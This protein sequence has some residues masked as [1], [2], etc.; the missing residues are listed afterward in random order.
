MSTQLVV[1]DR[2]GVINQDSAAFIRSAAEWHPIEGSLEAIAL[3]SCHGFTVAVATNQSGL[4]R[5]HF[6]LVTLD[7]IHGTMVDA[8]DMAGG[9]IDRIVFCPHSPDAGCACRKPAPGLLRQLA[10]HYGIG[11]QNVPFIGDS[12]RDLQAARAVGA[13]GM[14]VRSG[15]G[16]ATEAAF[17]DSAGELEVFDNLLQ[18]ARFLVAEKG[19]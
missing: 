15:K 18:A 14:L 5:G 17:A 11:L 16:R 10:G 3:L 1:L 12:L 2:D 8:V 13:R 6:D 4:A 9:H 19:R 7:K